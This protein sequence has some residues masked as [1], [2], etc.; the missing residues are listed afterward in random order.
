LTSI[1]G[2][3]AKPYF[4]LSAEASSVIAYHHFETRTSMADQNPLPYHLATP[5]RAA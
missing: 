2:I 3:G 1:S 5:Q 4:G